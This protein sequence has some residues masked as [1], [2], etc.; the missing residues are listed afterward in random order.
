MSCPLG[1]STIFPLNI[2]LCLKSIKNVFRSKFF[3]PD[4]RPNRIIFGAFDQV[5]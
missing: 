5:R 2:S 3:I 1:I 4:K